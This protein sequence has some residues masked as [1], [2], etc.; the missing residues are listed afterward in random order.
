MVYLAQEIDLRVAGISRQQEVH[1]LPT[2]VLKRLVA[3]QP[4]RQDHANPV[5]LIPLA[6]D[7][8]AGAGAQN[9][10]ADRLDDRGNPGVRE[11]CERVQPA[12]HGLGSADVGGMHQTANGGAC[13]MRRFRGIVMVHGGPGH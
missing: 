6:D 7:V 11:R 10:L 4:S 13:T 1:D 8:F 5:R 3:G 2:A 9:P 12:D